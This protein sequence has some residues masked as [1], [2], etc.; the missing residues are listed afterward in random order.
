MKARA[1]VCRHLVCSNL[2]ARALTVRRP[3]CSC[4]DPQPLIF[5]RVGELT[6]SRGSKVL[7]ARPAHTG[8]LSPDSCTETC[9][10]R[11]E[12]PGRGGYLV[13]WR[14]LASPRYEQAEAERGGPGVL[15]SVGDTKE[16]AKSRAGQRD[17]G[18]QEGG[19]E[20]V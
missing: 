7:G 18:W 13:P 14:P 10:A 2:Q 6:S 1:H 4:P 16:G 11:G 8:V 20:D 5:K 19:T 9:P 17:C 15:P 12:S 3:E